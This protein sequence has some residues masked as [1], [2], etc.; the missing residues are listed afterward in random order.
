MIASPAYTMTYSR[1]QIYVSQHGDR[2]IQTL[3]IMTRRLQ[4]FLVKQKISDV[5]K[6]LFPKKFNFQIINPEMHSG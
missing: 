4:I 6:Q 2:I 3:S 5:H 1:D